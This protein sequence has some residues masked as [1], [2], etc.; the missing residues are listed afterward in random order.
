MNAARL[1]L[2]DLLNLDLWHAVLLLVAADLFDPRLWHAVAMLCTCVLAA[3][4]AVASACR[5][6]ALNPSSHK[7]GWRVMYVAYAAFAALVLGYVISEQPDSEALQVLLAG[8]LGI[9]LNLALTHVQWRAN[10]VPPIACKPAPANPAFADSQ[11]DT[12]HARLANELAEQPWTHYKT[13]Q[14]DPKSGRVKA[15]PRM[16]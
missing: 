1:L 8:L 11:Y 4:V 2:A 5:V 15:P 14:P 7:L 12:D 6:N 10:L 16:P 3:L 9:G 13:H